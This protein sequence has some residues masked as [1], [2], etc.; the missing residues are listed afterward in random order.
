MPQRVSKFV[1]HCIIPRITVRQERALI[2]V[3]KQ[4]WAAAVGTLSLVLSTIWA[5]GARAEHPPEFHVVSNLK[6]PPTKVP[7][8]YHHL[9]ISETDTER[10]LTVTDSRNV[11]TIVDVSDGSSPTLVRQVQLPANVAHGDPVVLMGGM[12]L[13]ADEPGATSRP[14][15]IT[16]LNLNNNRNCNVAGRFE[17]VTGMEIDSTQSHIYLISGDELWILGG[18]Q[19]WHATFSR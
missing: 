18:R 11:M 12:A 17:N 14:R 10:F 19:H 13:V 2:T 9:H 7:N 8:D 1:S 6:L 4:I 5:H 15:T 3:R 16:L